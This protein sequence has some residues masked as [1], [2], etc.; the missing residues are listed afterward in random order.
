MRNYHMTPKHFYM[1]TINV[2]HIWSL[3]KEETRNKYR[4]AYLAAKTPEEKAL[5]KAPV[6]NLNKA[7][8]FKVLGKSLRL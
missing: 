8:Y 4:N 6:F 3:V 5:V 1:P 7:G 2:D